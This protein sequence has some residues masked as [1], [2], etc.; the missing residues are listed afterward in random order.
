MSR[1]F[2]FIGILLVDDDVRRG[3][4]SI[5]WRYCVWMS[6]DLDEVSYNLQPILQL[7][8]FLDTSSVL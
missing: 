7:Q 5:S 1:T 4:P 3:T 8:S 2:S 6:G